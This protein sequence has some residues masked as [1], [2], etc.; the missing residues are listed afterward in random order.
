MLTSEKNG[1]TEEMKPAPSTKSSRPVR[2]EKEYRA[3][4]ILVET[5]EQA[6]DLIAQLNK[7]AKFDDLARKHSKD[8]A[9]RE[10]GGDLDW[11]SQRTTLP[12]FS[13]A[14]TQLERASTPPE[15][16]KSQFGY[17]I[18]GWKTCVHLVPF[19]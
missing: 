6:K 5:E 18:I 12:E 4:H 1:T 7:G 10:N 14:L 9:L 19:V 2:G 16:V 11:A 3:R 13:K 8:P 15:P 17:H